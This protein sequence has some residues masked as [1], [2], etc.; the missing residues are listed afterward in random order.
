MSEIIKIGVIV[1]PTV[2]EAGKNY[3][4]QLAEHPGIKMYYGQTPEVGSH[5]EKLAVIGG[6]GTVRR[7]IKWVYESGSKIPIAV[8]EGGS[9][10]VTYNGLSDDGRV[11]DI[12]QYGETRD[13]QFEQKYKM[14]LG[15]AHDESGL[16]EL[17]ANHIDFGTYFE[18]NARLNEL[19]RHTTLSKHQKTRRS[20]ARAFAYP[21]AVARRKQFIDNYSISPKIGEVAVYPDFD[22]F[23]DD[24]AHGQSPNISRISEAR[25][26]KDILLAWKKGEYAPQKDLQFEVR[27]SYI[28][29]PRGRKVWID[30]DSE[31]NR[32]KGQ[33][34]MNRTEEYIL[35]A[36]E[37]PLA[38]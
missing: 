3:A 8:Y 18:I 20:L 35:L 30:G 27:K 34:E 36:L 22:F 15:E 13:Y 19:L 33:V 23:G 29:T 12:E 14:R 4:N 11:M 1:G 16:V 5:L 17:F 6:E 7:A 25:S 2:N 31:N 38:A 26:G 21:L 10:N 24:I 37:P 32:F 9:G 28:T